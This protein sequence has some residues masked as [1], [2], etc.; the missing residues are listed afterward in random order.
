ME[1]VPDGLRF[2]ASFAQTELGQEHLELYA[3]KAMDAFSVGFIPQERELEPEKIGKILEK[4]GIDAKGVPVS[5][6]TTKAHVLEVSAVCLGMNM[7]ALV[8]SNEP[9]AVKALERLKVEG[10]AISPEGKAIEA[11]A[12]V[13]GDK[14]I[15]GTP[16]TATAST[17]QTVEVKIE[18]PV[19]EPEPADADKIDA[20]LSDVYAA[21]IALTETA[22]DL[23]TVLVAH[24]SATESALKAIDARVNE[25]K[26][27]LDDLVESKSGEPA[28][29]ACAAPAKADAKDKT[30]AQSYLADIYQA[31][32]AVKETL[33]R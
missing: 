22:K 2:E 4:N 8:K 23:A 30:L 29:C 15:F 7:G 20:A 9:I 16:E 13:K 32:K 5:R 33:K 27:A 11:V 1:I 10:V 31:A 28:A 17:A 3:T 14:V 25:I 21:I 26:S 6:V 18:E 12:E 19:K 24:A